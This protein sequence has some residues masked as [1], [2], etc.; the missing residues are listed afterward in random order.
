MIMHRVEGLS[1]E[2]RFTDSPVAAELDEKPAAAPQDR[3]ELIELGKPPI[4]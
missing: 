4:E 3:L 2:G 1:N